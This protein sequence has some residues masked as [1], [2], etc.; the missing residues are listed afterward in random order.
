[1]NEKDYQL[2]V[3]RLGI[4][5]EAFLSSALG[6]YLMNR[7]DDLIN[8]NTDKLVECDPDDIKGNTK[9]RNEI[10]IGG[11]FKQFLAEAI[12]DGQNTTMQIRNQE[13]LS[14]DGQE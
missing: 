1:M 9:F 12:L 6:R 7:A 14:E 4:E 8:T 2:N 3:A 10:H 13:A 5:A 11:L